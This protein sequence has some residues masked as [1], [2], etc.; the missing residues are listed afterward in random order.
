MDYSFDDHIR[1]MRSM[2]G[3]AEGAGAPLPAESFRWTGRKENTFNSDPA[4]CG[5]VMSEQ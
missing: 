3:E 2:G 1:G 5:S 4:V